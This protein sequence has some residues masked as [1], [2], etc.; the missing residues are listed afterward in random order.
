[1]GQSRYSLILT[2]N[3]R[4]AKSSRSFKGSAVG[5]KETSEREKKIIKKTK[6]KNKNVQCL[7]V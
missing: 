5:I 3:I 4:Y 6:K 2:R 1:M 7:K